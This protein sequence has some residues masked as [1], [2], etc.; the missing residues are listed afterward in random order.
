M[1]NHPRKRAIITGASS[2]IGRTVA[3]EL[4]R[5][6]YDVA[7]V[8]RRREL[9]EANVAELERQGTR[10]A[11]IACDVTDAE[12]VKDAVRRGEEALGGSFDLAVANAGVGLPTHGANFKLADAELMLRVN[13]FGMIYLFDAVIPGMV[14]RRSGR[15]AGVA[16]LAGYRGIPASSIYSAS[17]AAMQSFLEAS[18]VE[19]APYGVGVTTIN[20]GFVVTAMTEKNKFKMPFLMTAERA[21]TIIGRGLD[22]G[23]RVIEFP[24]PMSLLVRLMRLLPNAIYDRATAPFARRKVDP[25]KL[26][27]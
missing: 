16:S 2:G 23:V 9:L 27:R 21:A 4:G 12:A 22:R 5:R 25:V 13:V 18:R 15:F 10:A 7:L 20:P 14:E 11:A 3:L 1:T 26:R 19:L 17:K 6:G 24:L 8:A